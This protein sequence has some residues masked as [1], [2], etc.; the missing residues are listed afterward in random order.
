M[1][2]F[3]YKVRI[4]GKVKQDEIEAEDKK[5][6]IAKLRQKNIRPLYIK[7][8]KGWGVFWYLLE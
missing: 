2:S 1:P 8:K 3:K 7:E 4:K 6:A 5:T